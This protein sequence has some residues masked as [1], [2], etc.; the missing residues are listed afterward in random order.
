MADPNFATVMANFALA[1]KHF[2]EFEQKSNTA[3]TGL[4]ATAEAARDAIRGDLG[5]ATRDAISAWRA[6]AG[7]LLA[8]ATVR[9]WLAPQVNQVMVAISETVSTGEANWAA[10]YDYMHANSQSVNGRAITFGAP[11][12]GGGNVGTP[13]CVRCTVDENGYPL[14]GWWPD[15]FTLR[16]ERDVS[17]IG[18]EHQ[19]VW[20]FRGTDAALDNLVRGGSGIRLGVDGEGGI[21]ELSDRFEG[22]VSNPSFDNVSA[23]GAT[24]TALTGWQTLSGDFTA[25]ETSTSIYWLDTTNGGTPRSLRFVGNDTVYQEFRDTRATFTPDLPYVVAYAVYRRDTATGTLT[26]RLAGGLSGG[27]SRAHTVGSLSDNAWTFFYLLSSG[28]GQ[29]SWLKGFNANALTLSFKMETLATGTVHLDGIVFAPMTRVG[30]HRDDQRS[31]RGATGTYIAI[32]AGATPSL[33]G[34]TFAISDSEST[35]GKVQ[36][37]PGQIAGMGYLPSNNAGAETIADV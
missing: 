12:A 26:A 25:L 3:T 23:S 5:E 24:I 11:S 20:S 31:G 1:V 10:L 7:P 22:V 4:I 2:E 18:L 8:P 32:C 27:I 19:A 30:Q 29:N 33:R 13:S 21:T 34:D 14:E 9:S 28:P 36:F 16:C 17:S 15:T 35:R 6:A 37:W